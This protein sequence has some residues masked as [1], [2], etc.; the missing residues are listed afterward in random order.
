MGPAPEGYR[1][2]SYEAT[3]ST[4]ERVRVVPGMPNAS[5]LVRRI[6]GQSRPPMPLDGPPYLSSDEIRLIEDWIMQGARDANGN[7]ARFPHGAKIRL[8]GTLEPQWQLDGLALKISAGTRI[9][10]SPSPG[11]YVRVRGRLSENGEIEV[12]RLRRR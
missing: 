1:L 9:R 7:M 8:H 4:H 11:D 10:K 2:T 6:R 5:E 3:L 12:E